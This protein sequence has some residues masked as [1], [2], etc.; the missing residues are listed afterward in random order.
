MARFAKRLQ[1]ER[2]ELKAAE[3]DVE[4][5]D[6]GACWRVSRSWNCDT[7]PITLQ[8]DRSGWTPFQPP[9]IVAGPL[10][11]GWEAALP[12]FPRFTRTYSSLDPLHSPSHVPTIIHV[13]S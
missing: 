6:G 11:F 9:S 1:K 12:D 3:Y 7:P 8:F 4:E 10:S 13:H 2:E 5:G